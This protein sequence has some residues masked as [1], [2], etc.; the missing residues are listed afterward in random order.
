MRGTRVPVRPG[1]LFLRASRAWKLVLTAPAQ[2]AFATQVSSRGYDP[3]EAIIALAPRAGEHTLRT[4]DILAAIEE[5]GKSIALVI[6]AG[7][8]YYTG[9]WF[10]MQKITAAAR[11]QVRALSPHPTT[12]R[13]DIPTS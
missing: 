10:E 8:Q 6:F 7:V 5:H 11:A 13:P 4:E 3:D 2:Y 12:S 1:A 9:Q